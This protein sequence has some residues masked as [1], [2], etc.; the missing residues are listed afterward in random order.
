MNSPLLSIIVPVYNVEDYIEECLNSVLAQTFKNFEVILVDDGSTDNSGKICDHYSTRD[1]RFR[2]IHQPNGGVSS[3][4]NAALDSCKG[5][6]LTMLD[7]DDSVAPDTYENVI[8]MEQHPDIDILQFPYVNCYPGGKQE[9]L[10]L[11]SRL[12]TGRD[13]ILLNWWEG[14]IL[15][16]ANLN[17]IF[18]H[19]VFENLRYR[20]GHVSEDTYLVADFIEKAQEVYIS[21][22]GRYFYKIR[23][24]S[25]TS[26]YTFNK[27]IDLFE[28]H[29]RTY[30]KLTEQP[31]SKP[32][33]VKA[34]TRLFRRLIS[35][36]IASP[37]S[38][39]IHYLQE[40]KHDM[41]RWTDIFANKGHS[42]TLWIIM[43]KLL[44]VSLFTKTFCWYLSRKKQA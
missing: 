2:S 29:I 38:D 15:H 9:L 20:V 41:P 5:K 6:Y 17:K 18:K 28:A 16:F 19:T 39:I 24:N 1:S 42:S 25:L 23:N 7:P 21:E 10:Q 8:Y 30:R 26:S 22:K 44:G 4:R 43:A 13:Q 31:L 3:A 35:A 37:Q 11:S 27:H 14:N 33:R 36:H 32:V 40:I 34:Y 12:I